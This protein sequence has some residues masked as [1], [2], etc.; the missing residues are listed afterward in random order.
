MITLA[1][2]VV[3]IPAQD[4]DPEEQIPNIPAIL[5]GLR[6]NAAEGDVV[7]VRESAKFPIEVDLEL[8]Q[9]DTVR[10]G[11]NSRLELLLQPGNLLRAGANTEVHFI[12]DR[13][14]RLKFRLKQGTLSF[15]LLKNDWEDTSDFFETLKQG[16]ELIR[17]I[18]P[19]AE[20]FITQPGVFR[21]N[22]ADGRTELIVRKGEA[23]IDGRRVKEKRSAVAAAGSVIVSEV[24]VK[25]EDVFDKWG[26]E[27]SDKLIEANRALKKDSPWAK[28]KEGR[29]P[30]VD[31][32]A[33]DQRNAGNPHVVSARP[34]AVNFVETGV[35]FTSADKSWQELTD[36]TILVPGDKVRTSRHSFAELTMFPDLYLRVDGES[37][38]LLEQLSN[39]SVAFKVLRGSAILDVARF[40]RKELPEI[41]ISGP[42]G[43]AVVAE[44]GNYRINAKPGTDE[45][46]VRRGKVMIQ[47]RSIGSCRIITSG[48]TFE[49]DRKITD[50]FDVWSQH[51][52]EGQHFTGSVMATRLGTL[53]RRRFK[54]TG[55][56][57]QPQPAGQYTFV[58]FFSTYFRSPY[59]GTYSSVLS[60]RRA[61]MF[62]YMHRGNVGPMRGPSPVA[63][64]VRIP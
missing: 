61:R 20:V 24:D 19:N 3:Q 14:D 1:T 32:P 46:I 8:K 6:A 30:I 13:D 21:I 2:L 5:H 52:G 53:R 40:D 7:Y 42:S 38:V 23:L 63:A 48:N 45:I 59:G 9:A 64:P 58:P 56:W 35:E 60:P 43:S 29:E 31:I 18:T 25:V 34:G 17:V 10:T 15:E 62:L 16:F 26:R 4:Q 37:E 44:E 27:R 22:T 50:N 49:C 39:E 57:Y 11:A 51:R 54:N 33:S 12:D 28:K 41:T 55:F 47:D 36:K